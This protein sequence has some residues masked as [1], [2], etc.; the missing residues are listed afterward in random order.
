M[1]MSLRDWLSKGWLVEHHTSSQ[2]IN[3][4]LRLVD[5]DISDSQVSGLTADWRLNIA[6]NSALQVATAALA[7][8]GYRASREAHHVRVIRSLEFTIGADKDLVMELDGFRK[9]RN[10]SDYERAGQVS[11]G[12][13]ADMLSLALKLKEDVLRWFSEEHP[14]LFSEDPV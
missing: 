5:R 11:D 3:D 9:K 12:E 10:I 7:A 1:R 2:E 14:E 8:T 6:Y 13:A 4:L